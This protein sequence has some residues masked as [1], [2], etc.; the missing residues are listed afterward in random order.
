MGV[1]MA[2]VTGLLSGSPSS[3][4]SVASNIASRF[5]RDLTDS[6]RARVARIL[7]S[8]DP[9][10]VRRAISDEGAM[11]ALQNRIQ[12]LT[13]IGTKGSARAGAVT[14]AQP[15]ATFSQQTLRGLL[16]Q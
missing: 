5:T 15:G 14:S 16:A 7:V 2:D 11:A 1:S 3:M 8:E 9:D 6:E 12:Q 10:L 4:L 13:T